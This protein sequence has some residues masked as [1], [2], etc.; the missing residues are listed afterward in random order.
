MPPALAPAAVGVANELAE[1]SAASCSPGA[2]NNMSPRQQYTSLRH[3]GLQVSGP[4][5]L[6]TVSGALCG[7]I[8]QQCTGMLRSVFEGWI[9]FIFV[10]RAWIIFRLRV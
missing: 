8:K 9:M 5:E 4:T 3:L 10:E 1:A 2:G 7:L 6:L